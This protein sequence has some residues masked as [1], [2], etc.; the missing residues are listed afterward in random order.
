MSKSKRLE[1][2][3]PIYKMEKDSLLSRKG[4]I[5]IGFEITLPE[6][7]TLSNNDYE[8][9]HQ[10]WIKA[11]RLLPVHTI[12]Q[13]Q[14]WF[15]QTAYQADFSNLEASFLSKSSE[16][17]FNERPFLDHKCYIYL[18]K[19]PKGN[20]PA[21]SLTSTLLKGN[22]VPVQTIDPRE[23]NI[24]M[25][26]VGQ[27]IKILE[28]SSYI[29]TKRLTGKDLVGTADSIGLVERYCF[30]LHQEEPP[31][32]RDIKFNETLEIGDLHTQLFTLS[33]IEDLP[34]L[35][36]PRVNYDKYSTDKTKFS[37]SFAAPLGLLLDCNHI[38]NQYVAIEDSQEILRKMEGKRLKLQSLSAYSR[39]NTIS[40]DSVNQFLNEAI[41]HQRLPVKGHFNI[42]VWTD[43][44]NKAKE[45]RNDVSAALAQIDA[46]T[47]QETVIAPQLFF[48]GIPGAAGYL[49]LH[50]T[51]DTFAEQASCF[52]NQ[53][54]NYLS[55]LSPV[56]LRLGDRISGMPVHADISDEP[57]RKGICTNRNKFILGGSG[58]YRATFN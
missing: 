2:M 21:T 46:R 1:E 15:I 5:T 43:D 40:R 18:T 33:D 45:I 32:I 50:E 31:V 52:F 11:I 57:I 54:T 56:G 4:D 22:L 23:L 25:D 51:F 7:F 28:D 49:P 6:I 8:A 9:L 20:K 30:L 47:K 17:F 26:K 53:E 10:A 27:F 44:K 34:S 12:L 48:A 35:C 38:Y 14:D 41:S 55:S 19:K 29:K 3:L 36:G 13:K 16:R 39:E 42:L 24:F 37:V 58:S